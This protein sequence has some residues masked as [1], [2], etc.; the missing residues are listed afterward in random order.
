MKKLVLF[1][2]VLLYGNLNAQLVINEG[3]NKN[4]NS[5]LDE[6]D[7][8]E[9][10]IEIYN[11]GETPLNLSGYSLS[12]DELDLQKW[13]FS[14]YEIQPGEFLLVF[15]SGKDNSLT[16]V[17]QAA[18]FVENYTPYEG[19]NTHDF[20][21]PFIW[22]GESNILVDVCSYY[23]QGYT[24]NSNFYQSETSFPSTIVKVNDGSDASCDSYTGDIY[25]QRPNTRF[26]SSVIGE[27]DI[28]NC[29]TCYPAPYGN[30][31]WSARN[32]M[33]FTS[34]ELMESGLSEG[35]INNISW[36]VEGTSY[37]N[38]SYISIKIKHTLDEA[39]TSEFVNSAG[40]YFHTN[41][42]ISSEGETIFLTS[43]SLDIISE[44]HV[45]SPSI[46]TSLGSLPDGSSSTHILTL[47]TPGETNG[48]S[49]IPEGICSTPIIS[50]AGGIYSL[51][52]EVQ[53]YNTGDEDTQVRYT[54]NGDEPDQNSELYTGGTIDIYQSSS[55]R[56]RAFKENFVPSPITSESYLLNVSH[57]TPI[58]SINID[59]SS[60]YGGEGIFDH[61]AEDWERFAQ[62]TYYDSTSF[63]NFVFDRDAAMQID[64]GAGGSRSHA[65]H[66]FRLE[67]AKGAFN[68]LPVDLGLLSNRP[69]R[70][71]YSRLYFRNG[72]NQWLNL[73]YKDACLVDMLTRGTYSYHSA[74]RPVSV[75]INGGYFGIYEMREKLDGEFWQEYDN[76]QDPE[77]VDVISL[78]YWYDLVLRATEGQVTD[79]TNSWDDF[80][81]LD[82]QSDSF[83]EQANAIYDLQNYSDYIISQ[84]WINNYDWPYNNIKIYRSDA[85]DLR[86]KFA[87]IDLELSLA[88]GGW[89]GCYENGLQHII[90]QGSNNS[91]VGAWNRSM[92][93]EEYR[94]YFINRFADL[95]NTLYLPERL[96]SIE[97]RYFNEWALEMPQEYQRWGD[98]DDVEE[99]MNNFYARHNALRDDLE[100]KTEVVRDQ[101]QDALDLD[102]QFDLLLNVYPENAGVIHLNTI[103]P[104]SYPWEGVY[105]KGIPIELTAQ[106]NPGF[107]FI[108]WEDNSEIEDLLDSYWTGETYDNEMSFTALFEVI[109]GV[110]ETDTSPS[111][112]IYPNPAKNILHLRSTSDRILDW[113]IYNAQGQL[114]EAQANRA[115]DF[116]VT[117]D[118]RGL[119]LGVYTI[120]TSTN[121]GNHLNRWIKQ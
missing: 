56:A 67:L 2:L 71:T 47:T 111:V 78:S 6:D 93:N 39:V 83:I 29:N 1:C 102:G 12:D 34:E 113:K 85:S 114:V 62:I 52:L 60:L 86:W 26:N 37:E 59:N 22:D 66:S 50:E 51:T 76:Y 109:D 20:D 98:P 95:N 82:T 57:T 27:D 32:Q 119:S 9:D 58:V 72:S 4:F 101:I 115:L 116:Q 100:C 16:Q 45:N 107:N 49:I 14:D 70:D 68:E 35:P 64:G 8:S 79:Y 118:I 106:A 84:G 42:K 87:T 117:L 44:L 92:Y 13:T 61:W 120:S 11:S 96:L 108:E 53:I 69:D 74:M 30:W 24:S 10:W 73:P 31:Y 25:Y 63:H 104:P 38:Y 99:E 91:F 41:F 89:S 97:Q 40:E 7:E 110:E 75:Y 5:I 19:W 105:Y 103:T 81:A 33:L 94:T 88:P 18:A 46:F 15:C 65:Q 43:P 54:T 28:V 80:Q 112:S 21:Q 36:D 121:S 48:T 17:F 23:N 77:S 90:N 3:S 55:I